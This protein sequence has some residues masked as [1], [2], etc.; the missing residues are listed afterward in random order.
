MKP[1]KY[2]AAACVVVARGDRIMLSKRFNMGVY[3]G[4]WQMPGGKIE[5]LELPIKAAQRELKKETGLN[6][7]ES[8]FK[9]GII[10]KSD[11][12]VKKL[13]SFRANL[14]GQETPRVVEIDKNGPWEFFVL[15]DVRVMPLLPATLEIIEHAVKSGLFFGD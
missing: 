2:K 10:S 1:I 4:L 11:P 8:R 3:D 13:H 6:L 14:F 9:T 15:D 7:H 5:P 12:T